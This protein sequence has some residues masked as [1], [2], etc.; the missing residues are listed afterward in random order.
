M[1]YRNLFL[2]VLE[3]GKSKI[4]ALAELTSGGDLI[5]EWVREL[6]AVVFVYKGTNP[7]HEGSTP[8]T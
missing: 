3:D 1:N 2:T 4:K 7:I 6:S 5:P 8:M